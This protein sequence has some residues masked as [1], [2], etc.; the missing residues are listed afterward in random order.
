MVLKAPDFPSVL[1]ELGFVS[2]AQDVASM[3]SPEWRAQTAASMTA[4]VER[5]MAG[6]FPAGDGG[7]SGAVT[8]AH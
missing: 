6:K 1:V 8:P 2:N 3:T 5:F 4:A 7:E